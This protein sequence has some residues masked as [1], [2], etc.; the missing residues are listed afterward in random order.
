M[1]ISR[2]GAIAYQ[3]LTECIIDAVAMSP[4]GTM[5]NAEISAK[6]GLQ[7]DRNGSKPDYLVWSILQTHT[8]KFRRTGDKYSLVDAHR[9]TCGDIYAR[10]QEHLLELLDLILYCL[11]DSPVGN[12]DI[13]RKLNIRSKNQWFS[14]ALLSILVNQGLIIQTK[15][16]GPY[17][18]TRYDFSQLQEVVHRGDSGHS[19]KQ[20]SWLD[21]IGGIQHAKNTGEYKIPGTNWYAD[22]YCAATNT[23]YEFHGCFWHGCPKHFARESIN[24]ISKRKFGELYDSTIYRESIIRKLGYNLV[25][26][27]ECEYKK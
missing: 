22:G 26:I 17:K 8:D 5:T 21:S 13:E 6:L 23:I 9:M 11:L 1:D 12:S 15:S 20:I 24:A 4:G 10:T 27:W 25:V 3:G 19:G 16:R 18:V 7:C 14:W 2:A